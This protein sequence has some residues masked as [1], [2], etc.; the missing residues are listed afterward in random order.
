MS[1]ERVS[2]RL[3]YALRKHS[4]GWHVTCER[5]PHDILITATH[6]ASPGLRFEYPAEWDDDT[7]VEIARAHW[8]H[9]EEIRIASAAPKI[10][11]RQAVEGLRTMIAALRWTSVDVR[12]VSFLMW[13]LGQ[14]TREEA[15]W[16]AGYLGAD[17][18]NHPIYPDDLGP[19]G[20]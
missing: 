5:T 19:P 15:A 8:Q 12:A 17:A 13:E 11:N 1:E 4:P 14:L 6:A 20:N 9:H 16:I 2:A 18:P 7:V 3:S 10:V